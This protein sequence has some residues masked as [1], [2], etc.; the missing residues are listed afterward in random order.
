[1]AIKKGNF[2]QLI[3]PAPRALANSALSPFSMNL[4]YARV[5]ENM[6]P[7]TGTAGTLAKRFGTTTLGDATAVNFQRLMYYPKSDGTIQILAAFAD[8]T[9]KSLNEG[10][11]A[12]TN[13]KTGLTTTGVVRWCLF[14]EKLIIVN[15]VD[16]PM[17]W[18]G[19]SISN[20]V[21]SVHERS[22]K[23]WVDENKIKITN[24]TDLTTRYAAADTLTLTFSGTNLAITSITRSGSTATATTTAN[25]N[26]ETGD[27]VTIKNA[28]E[29]EYNG[30][31]SITSTGANTF[32]YTVS[33]T[34][35][36]PA[37]VAT[38]AIKA[39]RGSS[40]PVGGWVS[41][42]TSFN[43]STGVGLTAPNA[44]GVKVTVRDQIS[45]AFQVKLRYRPQGSDT[46]IIGETK[47]LQ[48]TN[49]E[50]TLQV[51]GLPKATYEWTVNATGLGNDGYWNDTATVTFEIDGNTL[52]LDRGNIYSF[53]D[54]GVE[55]SA[56]VISDD[57]VIIEASSLT[58]T[59]GTATFTSSATHGLTT[60]D[61][62][63]IY[64]ALEPEYNTTAVIT[65]GTTTTFTFPIEGSPSSPATVDSSLPTTLT[66]SFDRLQ[67]S[68][69]IQS[70]SFST[71]DT[72]IT[73]DAN[74]IPDVSVTID[75]VVY[76]DS[77]P[78]FSFIFPLN[79]RLWALAPKE[80]TASTFDAAEGDRMKVYYTEY[81]N[82]ENAWF[83]PVTQQ[84]AFIDVI[85]KHGVNDQLEAIGAVD[86]NLV[87]F[88]RYKT[89]VWAGSNPTA[90]GD[91]THQKTLPI[92]VPSGDLVVQFPRDLLF[93]TKYGARSL[94]TVF[95]TD[96]LEA[97]TDI[98][99]NQDPAIQ[100]SVATLL[101]SDATFKTARAFRYDRDGFYGF[102]VDTDPYIYVLSEEAKGWTRFTGLFQ[103]MAD[104]VELPDGRLILAKTTQLY[105][106]ANGADGADAVYSDN[107]STYKT[108]WTTPW[109]RNRGRWA[110]IYW[111]IVI[112]AG[113]PSQL[114]T[115]KRY[116]NDLLAVSTDYNTTINTSQAVWDESDWDV[117]DWDVNTDTQVKFR[118]NFKGESFAFRLESDT[119]VGPL[120]INSVIAYGS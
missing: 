64:D 17:V 7:D 52:S 9:I 19:T 111:Q 116:K 61:V 59:S 71:P 69:T 79:N 20:M 67:K 55:L 50:T 98:G 57:S 44:S 113:A 12:W 6:L 30:T 29:T 48:D 81:T 40:K 26:L 82:N 108:V 107:G 73:F 72:T 80:L 109:I 21:D 74:E 78:A 77:P 42:G 120:K 37:S 25:H 93:F 33:G 106:Y 49:G 5:I 58:Q 51:T 97:V 13:V 15:G 62:V 54:K 45:D 84:A 24:T 112:E 23:T 89:Q 119:A 41:S 87:F 4:N 90:S 2:R 22:V 94:R 10:T 53:V 47:R 31:Y 63:T 99:S 100:D 86:G 34:P 65:V 8:G 60:G 16:T 83:N 110:N 46:W 101:G 70:S 118:D 38:V 96:A 35:S 104:A 115:F 88:G 85:N 92:G 43:D 91:L 27:Y 114:L 3:I 75:D 56:G 76:S 11:G 68:V 66:Y 102:R 18:N 117:V 14:N 39:V 95:Q 103:S 105:V 28:A 1:M 36:S 32:T